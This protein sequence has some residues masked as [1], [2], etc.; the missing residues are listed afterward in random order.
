MYCYM[1]KAKSKIVCIIIL[2]FVRNYVCAYIFINIS[3][4]IFKK[5]IRAVAIRGN[6]W[7]LGYGEGEREI[8]FSPLTFL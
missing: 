7:W 1:K 4:N 2:A 8:Y 6:S 3:G 5:L